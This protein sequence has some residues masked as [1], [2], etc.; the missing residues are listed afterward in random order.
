MIMLTGIKAFE[1]RWQSLKDHYP[2]SPDENRLLMQSM[3]RLVDNYATQDELL[4][5]LPVQLCIIFNRLVDAY[6]NGVWMEDSSAEEYSGSFGPRTERRA[7]SREGMTPAMLAAQ[8]LRRQ[9]KAATEASEAAT[10]IVE[11]Y[12]AS[13]R[14]R[15]SW[16]AC[17][18]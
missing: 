13:E 1:A 18:S 5:E 16:A 4:D 9:P 3:G 15:S 2:T 7:V 14:R 11:T 10:Y 17:A 12:V 8:K 6:L